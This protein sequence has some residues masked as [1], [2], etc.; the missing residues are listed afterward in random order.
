MP[1]GN[2]PTVKPA[3]Q[4]LRERKVRQDIQAQGI[5][6]AQGRASLA[7]APVN[8]AQAQANL[9]LA[10][11]NLAQAQADLAK[12]K[13]ESASLANKEIENR[14]QQ[15][16]NAQ[17]IRTQVGRA[18]NQ[19]SFFN[20]GFPGA[21]GSRIPGSSTKKLE[22]TLA[23]IKANLSF[24]ALKQMRA[25]SPTGGALGNVSNEELA[26]LAAS[27]GALDVSQGEEQLDRSL[28]DIN[29]RYLSIQ[30]RLMGTAPAG[31]AAPAAGGKAT[32]KYDKNGNRIP[33]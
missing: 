6:M 27:A 18:I 12:S 21:F 4:S 2:D 24:E 16:E 26:L 20:T 33:G 1:W 32:Y 23:P 31:A 13:Q 10:P 7:Q 5:N 17:Y 25:A 9:T 8:L 29:K 11:V 22:S 3:P 14:R 30:R 19:S 28:N 15:L